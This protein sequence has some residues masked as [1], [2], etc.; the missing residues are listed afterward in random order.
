[1]INQVL[2]YIGA[3]YVA[4]WGIAHLFPTNSVVADFGYL[5]NTLRRSYPLQNPASRCD[6]A[7]AV[8]PGSRRCD[9][10]NGK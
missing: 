8:L 4:F 9:T 2:T 1:M 5:I 7:S 6:L 3:G 10:N